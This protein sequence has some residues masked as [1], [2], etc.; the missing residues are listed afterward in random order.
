MGPKKTNADRRQARQQ[1]YSSEGWRRLRYRVL[2]TYGRRCM[3]CGSDPKPGQAPHVDHIKPRS[4]YPD[5]E[6]RFD[7]MQVLCEDCN[8]GKGAADE[9]DWRP[10]K[11]TPLR[12]VS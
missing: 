11:P 7:N 5:L 6:L 1:F 2:K 10:Q 4:R 8:M 3:C 9:T 12:V